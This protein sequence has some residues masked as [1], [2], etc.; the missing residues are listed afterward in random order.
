MNA[1]ELM[2]GLQLVLELPPVSHA[3][4]GLGLGLELGL[5]LGL[6]S[7]AALDP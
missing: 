2:C 6:V 4:L 5:G 3:G 1:V 7:H